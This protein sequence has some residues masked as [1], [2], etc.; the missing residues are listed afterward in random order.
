MN[1]KSVGKAAFELS[2]L[3]MINS[4]HRCGEQLLSS[5]EADERI[6]PNVP[7][8]LSDNQL[9]YAEIGNESSEDGSVWDAAEPERSDTLSIGRQTEGV[10]KA[11]SDNVG[12]SPPKLA[13]L[14]IDSEGSAGDENLGGS[15]EI[16]RKSLKDTQIYEKSDGTAEICRGCEDGGEEALGDMAINRVDTVEP[17]DEIIENSHGIVEITRVGEDGRGEPVSCV[18]RNYEYT[19]ES[20][21]PHVQINEKS[22]ENL[23]IGRRRED[24]GGDA[25]GCVA[26]NKE[27]TM[28]SQGRYDGTFQSKVGG[29]ISDPLTGLKETSNPSH[30]GSLRDLERGQDSPKGRTLNIVRTRSG[31]RIAA[32]AHFTANPR[33]NSHDLSIDCDPNNFCTCEREGFKLV[34]FPGSNVDDNGSREEREVGCEQVPCASFESH[35]YSP[36]QLNGYAIVDERYQTSTP[37]GT[38]FLV[39]SHLPFAQSRQRKGLA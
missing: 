1:L 7:P 30:N 34:G 5:S 35:I 11:C 15:I 14:H 31:V 38:N 9:R 16:E 13:S 25:V 3:K 18:A 22:H 32:T 33:Y 26:I 6:D 23:E 8:D 29:Q 37:T 39:R 2:C 28:D 19:I 10:A 12:E 24:G 20:Q 17:Y 4:A 27:D 36:S 21:G